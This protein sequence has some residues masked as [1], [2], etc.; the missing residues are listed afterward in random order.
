MSTLK[1]KKLTDEK[2]KIIK[3]G[4]DRAILGRNIC[5]T[6][7]SESDLFLADHTTMIEPKMKV[8]TIVH[9]MFAAMVI[10][11][12]LIRIFILKY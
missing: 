5:R 3:R 10:I 4:N 1:F 6:Y 8:S 7:I 2:I 9:L 12:L 11:F